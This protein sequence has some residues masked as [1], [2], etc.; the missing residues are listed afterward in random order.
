ML[1]NEEF[2]KL[3]HKQV[4]EAAACPPAAMLLIEEVIKNHKTAS[5]SVSPY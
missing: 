5:V 4:S 3:I 1:D 2:Y